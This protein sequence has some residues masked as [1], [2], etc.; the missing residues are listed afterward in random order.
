M[1]ELREQVKPDAPVNRS[2]GTRE[3]EVLAGISN[4]KVDLM[5][6]DQPEIEIARGDT[7]KWSWEA[8]AAPHNVM[9]LPEGQD[10]PEFIIPE[11][12]EAGP[13]NLVVN[14]VV[15]EP[16]GGD[17]FQPGELLNSG[18]RFGPEVPPPP[19]FAT[20]AT[21]SLTFNQE[22]TFNYVCTLHVGQGMIGTINVIS[23]RP[24]A[25]PLVGDFA[26]PTVALASAA[27]LGFGLV[28][29]GGI[30]LVRRSGRKAQA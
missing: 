3:Y 27:T 6:F 21:Y 4:Q 9:F 30:L 2:G 22:G 24:T 19:G 26:P 12:Q 17:V 15:L 10:P 8:T 23:Q 11:P 25:A 13:P 14:P 18:V 20:G 28:V 29:F 5:H 16:A 1:N 7:V